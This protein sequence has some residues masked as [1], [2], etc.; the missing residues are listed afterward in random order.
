VIKD[1]ICSLIKKKKSLFLCLLIPRP[2]NFTGLLAFGGQALNQVQNNL[3]DSFPWDASCYVG[4]KGD[5]VHVY[6]TA[7]LSLHTA[8]LLTVADTERPRSLGTHRFHA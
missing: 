2:L 8:S 7:L 1:D 5:E 4:S 6:L 3:M